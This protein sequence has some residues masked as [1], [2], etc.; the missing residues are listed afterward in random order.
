MKERA[1]RAKRSRTTGPRSTG[2]RAPDQKDLPASQLQAEPNLNQNEPDQWVDDGKH[3][4]KKFSLNPKQIIYVGARASGLS[5]KESKLKAGYSPDTSTSTI[6]AA[7]SLRN[8]LLDAMDRVGVTSD[9]L[10]GKLASGLNAKSEHFFT[11]KGKVKDVKVTENH[12]IQQKYFRNA[13]EIRG[14]IKQNAVDTINVGV[15]AIPTGKDDSEWNAVV[16][17]RENPT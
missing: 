4:T 16:E 14:D 1:P 5:K 2:S 17:Q 11:F 13:L 15:V 9:Y 7:P 8:A 12:E 6:E 10:A 3:N